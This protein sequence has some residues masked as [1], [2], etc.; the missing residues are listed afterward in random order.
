MKNT[1]LVLS[2]ISQIITSNEYLIKA[3]KE[4]AEIDK[5]KEEYFKGYI[6]GLELSSFKIQTILDTLKESEVIV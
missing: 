6:R 3:L 4:E 2:T 1:D 5:S